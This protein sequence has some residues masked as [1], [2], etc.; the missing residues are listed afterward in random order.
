MGDPIYSQ[1]ILMSAL[2][3]IDGDEEAIRWFSRREFRL[4]I[5]AHLKELEREIAG[6][7]RKEPSRNDLIHLIVSATPEAK[8]N[9]MAT[10]RQWMR[11]AT[12]ID[13]VDPYLLTKITGWGEA[14]IKRFAN[15]L[16]SILPG[17][18]TV[19]V[20]INGYSKEVRTTVWRKIKEGRI[21]RLIQT[22]KFHDRFIVTDSG[23]KLMGASFNGLG[24]KISALVDLDDE[25]A[26]DI[27]A[28][29]LR[30]RMVGI[31]LAGP[32]F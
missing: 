12:Q 28:G 29:V 24:R 21:A 31:K 6:V 30:E 13:I 10:L 14:E 19:N 5:E 23:V 20:F 27:R 22:D 32:P 7:Q 9:A 3:A 11:D 8:H 26:A 17:G 15:D 18:A 25:D 2:K 4:G 16:D 1:F